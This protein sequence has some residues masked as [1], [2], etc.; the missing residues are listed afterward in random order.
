MPPNPLLTVILI[1]GNRRERVQRSL[2]AVLAQDIADQIVVIGFAEEHV[3]VPEGWARESLRLHAKGY[4]AVTGFFVSGNSQYRWARIAFA[5]T[6]GDYVLSNQIG[7]TT[8]IPGDNTS[9]IRSK[10]LPF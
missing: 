10:L 2:G 3:M 8:D 7:E 6:Y 4:A 9:F 1:A 5:I